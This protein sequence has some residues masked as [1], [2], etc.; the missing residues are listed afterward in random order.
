MRLRRLSVEENEEMEVGM[1]RENGDG[2]R[3]RL[4]RI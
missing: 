1:E 3:G 2:D 4:R